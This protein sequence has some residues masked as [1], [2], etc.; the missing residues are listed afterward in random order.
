MF[1]V[2]NTKQLIL[3]QEVNLDW[4]QT[5]AQL[6]RPLIIKDKL[7]VYYATRGL[8][9]GNGNYES[10][11]GAVILDPTNPY[12]VLSIQKTPV[13]KPS[14]RSGSFYETGVMPG[15]L[16]HC[17]DGSIEMLFTGWSRPGELYPFETW[18]GAVKSHDSGVS[19]DSA[20]V[21]K[22]VGKSDNIEFLANGPEIIEL[23]D[24]SS[25]IAFASGD[26]WVFHD[27]KWEIVYTIKITDY[28]VK[29]SNKLRKLRKQADGL[30]ENAPYAFS[31][32]GKTYLIYSLRPS[33]NFRGDDGYQL[34]CGELI[35]GTIV[36]EQPITFDVKEPWFSEMQCYAS[37]YQNGKQTYLFFSGNYFGRV[38]FGVGE[39]LFS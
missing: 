33:L 11:I 6:P 15:H 38:G 25:Q 22:I 13:F 4:Q 3:P 19:F 24:N 7:V 16:Q 36:D 23:P 21:R 8:A 1:H 14:R 31:H 18:I 2:R 20:S 30:C 29:S 5:H 39:I 17:S 27:G 12:R 35:N 32:L 37:V 28:P 26:E 34:Y 10:Y 9:D